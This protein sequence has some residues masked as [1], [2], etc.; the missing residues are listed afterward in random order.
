M[1]KAKKR[2]IRVWSKQDVRNLKG[3]AQAKFVGADDCEEVAAG[4]WGL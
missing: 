4:G 1:A 3:F 2:V